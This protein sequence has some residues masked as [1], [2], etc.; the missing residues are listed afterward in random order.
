MINKFNV[1]KP[2]KYT[3]KSGEE[4]TMW[5]NIG[6][7]TVFTKED[8]TQSRILEIPAIGLKANIFPFAPKVEKTEKPTEQIQTEAPN[9]TVYDE[10]GNPFNVDSIPF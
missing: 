10:Q 7:M 8:G 1:S 9:E 5:H 3:N 6:T 4:K 2:E